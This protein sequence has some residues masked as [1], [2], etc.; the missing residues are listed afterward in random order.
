MVQR[1]DL[2]HAGEWQLESGRWGAGQA[3]KE[4]QLVMSVANIKAELFAFYTAHDKANPGRPLTRVPKFTC[5]KLGVGQDRHHLKYK[6]KEIWGVSLYVLAALT[7]HRAGLGRAGTQYLQ[8]GQHLITFADS[9]K[10]FGPR[11]SLPQQRH[12]LG[13]WRGFMQLARELELLTPK[14][15]LMWHLILRSVEHGNPKLYAVFLDE[16]LNSEFKHILRLVHQA[17]FERLALV[18]MQEF[19]KRP[20]T[21]K[22]LHS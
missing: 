18:K 17:A 10:K 16:S 21:R 19:L 8:A 20:A 2:G 3:T 12:L 9:L 11:I 1:G 15:H 6:A 5:K 13:E 4:E 22:R 14:C 7:K